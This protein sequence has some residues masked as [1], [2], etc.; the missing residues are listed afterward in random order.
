[1]KEFVVT[2]SQLLEARGKESRLAPASCMP[3]EQLV[4]QLEWC[5][6]FACWL[7]RDGGGVGQA[8]EVIRKFPSDG[9]T[10]TQKSG[11]QFSWSHLEMLDVCRFT[12]QPWSSTCTW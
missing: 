9:D 7:R 2:I 3:L 6:S 4:I 10:S 11:N 1:M 12:I 5:S 8:L